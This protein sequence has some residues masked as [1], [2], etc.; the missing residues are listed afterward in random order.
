VPAGATALQSAQVSITN[1]GSGD[2]PWTAS[3][4]ATWLQLDQAGGTVT[5]GA[6]PAVLTLSADPSGLA[7]GTMLSAVVTISGASQT[8]TIPVSLSVG[9]V[10][11]VSNV[12]PSFLT[13]YLPLI[14]K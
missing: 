1:T 14:R 13:F 6:D 2:L 10:R 12:S 11:L 8:I 5:A 7:S 3:S 9:P 4:N